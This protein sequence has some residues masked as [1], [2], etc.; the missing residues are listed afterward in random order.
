M[1][2]GRRLGVILAVVM[3]FIGLSA[4]AL[5]SGAERVLTLEPAVVEATPTAPAAPATATIA[6]A[7]P[8]RGYA[9]AVF[10]TA[11]T[12]TSM[13]SPTSTVDPGASP[14]PYV[15]ATM[16]PPPVIGTR[17]PTPVSQNYAP[18]VFDTASTPTTTP[19]PTA[20]LEFPPTATFPAP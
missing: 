11:S 5:L 8:Y 13:L 6:P 1:F 3:L 10:D 20:T 15:T 12:P 4:G 16:P 7:G 18:A 2:T 9:P 19:V 17:T 14:T